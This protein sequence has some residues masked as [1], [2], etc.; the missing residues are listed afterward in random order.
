MAGPGDFWSQFSDFEDDDNLF[1]IDYTGIPD[2]LH[3]VYRNT[4]MASDSYFLYSPEDKRV[5]AED[6]SEYFYYGGGGIRPDQDAWLSQ[7][8]LSHEDF[9]WGGWG[10]LY[11]TVHG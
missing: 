10:E 6:F 7:L 2:F 9:D 4:V 3:G 1:E 5:I 8:G 11:D